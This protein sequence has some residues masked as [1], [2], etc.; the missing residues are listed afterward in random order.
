MA[1]AGA[2]ILLG[3]AAA[4]ALTQDAQPDENQQ[5]NDNSA[6]LA[7]PLK[8]TKSVMFSDSTQ[9]K[10]EGKVEDEDKERNNF[11]KKVRSRINLREIA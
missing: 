7:E 6:K 9:R 10:T 3:T 11:K 8:K 1:I 5:E 2:G 4:Y